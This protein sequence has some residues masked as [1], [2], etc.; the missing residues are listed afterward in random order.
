MGNIP[1]DAPDNIYQIS[2]DPN[3]FH[4]NL[5]STVHSYHGEKLEKANDVTVGSIIGRNGRNTCFR[6]RCWNCNN[7]MLY[8]KDNFYNIASDCSNCG[9]YNYIKRGFFS[10]KNYPLSTWVPPKSEECSRE[11]FTIVV[12]K[13]VSY[14]QPMLVYCTEEK[15]NEFLD[16]DSLWDTVNL[17]KV[18][19]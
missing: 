15:Y 6:G 18:I 17:L 12:N 8:Q 11:V 2:V 10:R 7:Q 5:L 4:L 19:E 14:Q 16:K 1:T 9:E 13:N 3:I